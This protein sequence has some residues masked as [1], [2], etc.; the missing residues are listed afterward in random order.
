VL[1]RSFH[2]RKN[3]ER[4]LNARSVRNEQNVPNVRSNYGC[5]CYI[6]PLSPEAAVEPIFTKVDT[7]IIIYSQF[8]INELTGFDSVRGRISSFPMGKR[9]RR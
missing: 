5:V 7:V 4:V 6:S 2:V 3:N 9:G 1:A 8:H